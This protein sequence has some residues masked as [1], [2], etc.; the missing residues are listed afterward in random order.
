VLPECNEY[1]CRNVYFLPDGEQT[2]M[3]GEVEL[4]WDRHYDA[5]F[6]VHA[7]GVGGEYLATTTFVMDDFHPE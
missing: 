5:E 3:R 4:Q 1:R 7:Y 6:T 2:T